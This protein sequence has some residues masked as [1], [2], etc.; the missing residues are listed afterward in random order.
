MVDCMIAAVAMSTGASLLAHDRNI[1]TMA[2]VCVDLEP[3]D[4]SAT[5]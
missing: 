3:D 1:A 4:H 2:T 5:G